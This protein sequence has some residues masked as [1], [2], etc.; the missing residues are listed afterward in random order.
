LQG[1][2]LYDHYSVEKY[3]FANELDPQ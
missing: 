1:V 3:D 2:D